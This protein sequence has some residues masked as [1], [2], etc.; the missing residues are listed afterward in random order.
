MYHLGLDA[1]TKSRCL[2][3]WKKGKHEDKQLRDLVVHP[4]LKDAEI[5]DGIDSTHRQDPPSRRA[6]M[7]VLESPICGTQKNPRDQ[8]R[9]IPANQK[10]KKWGNR[11]G[12]RGTQ[13][14]GVL[15]LAAAAPAAGHTRASAPAVGAPARPAALALDPRPWCAASPSPK[16]SPPR[17]RRLGLGLRAAGSR[18]LD[19]QRPPPAE[20][21][22]RGRGC[23]RRR[24]LPSLLHRA[25]GR[26]FAFYFFGEI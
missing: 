24:G 26:G 21:S 18:P 15:A 9:G 25:G 19:P 3:G 22:C 20:G 7:R 1:G 13:W 23:G 6:A 8:Q 10:P 14:A 16:P 12:S 11:A 4:N 2:P 17:W 5:I